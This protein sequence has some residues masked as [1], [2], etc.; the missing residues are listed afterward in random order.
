MKKCFLLLTLLTMSA[1]L[2]AQEASVQT[3]EPVKEKKFTI[4]PRAGFAASRFKGHLFHQPTGT[5]WVATA[6]SERGA[7]SSNILTVQ[8]ELLKGKFGNYNYVVTN[9]R[10]NK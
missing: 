6:Y 4:T 8:N 2:M 10:K 5:P 3:Q 7:S 9:V 1:S